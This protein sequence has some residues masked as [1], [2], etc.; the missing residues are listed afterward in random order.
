VSEDQ[1]WRLQ[2]VLNGSAEH[3]GPFERLIGR[4]RDEYGRA[5]AEAQEGVGDEVA[6]THDGERLF[7][8]ANEREVLADVRRAI[9][10]AC[11]HHGLTATFTVS[12][13]DTGYD[14]WRQVDPPESE[15]EAEASRAEDLAG[16]TVET[17]TVVVSSGR[18]LQTSLE[19]AMA[20]WAEKLGLECEIVEHPHLL[21]TQVAFKITGPRRRIEEF[22]AALKTD[23]WTSIRAD[24]FGTG[25]I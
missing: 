12:H 15:A 11:E 8:Y 10:S 24:G 14:R 20:D 1:D 4:T 17:Q 18:S 5:A 3:H 19:Q 13:W 2:A 6:I 9:E 23:S 21:S 16:D 7:A 22:R 25:L